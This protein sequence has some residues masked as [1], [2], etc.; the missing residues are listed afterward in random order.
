MAWIQFICNTTSDKA[1]ALSDAFSECG[2]AAVTFEDDADQPI[3]EPDLGTTPL[4]TATRVVALFDAETN[5]D[6]VGKMLSTLV[7]DIPPYRVEAV[8]DKDWE[9]EWMDN[10]HP[11]QFGERLW[12]CPSWHTPP[13]PDAVNIMLDPGLA[14]GTGTH[15]TTALCLNWLDQADLKGKYVIDYGCG[16]G[17][18]AIAAALLGAERVIGVDTDPQALEAT[19]ANAERNGVEIEAYLPG[20]CP[21]EPCDLLLAN[22]LAGP[23]QTLAP[24]FANLTKPSAELVLSGILE[25]QA[26]EVS[27]SYAAWFDMQAP[28]I[29]EDW[30]RLN[31]TRH[32]R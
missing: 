9:R 20:D 14:F 15:P 19:R 22:I 5:P 18:L 10:F 1:D 23:L 30:T 6:D 8:E 12:I 31:G 28:T 32:A 3:Y 11:I 2:A 25:V 29:K 13:A 17:I 26:Q 24:R 4:W 27:D 7:N 21:D 16:S